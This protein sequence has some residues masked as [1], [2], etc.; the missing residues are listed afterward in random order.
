MFWMGCRVRVCMCCVHYISFWLGVWGIPW[1]MCPC[2]RMSL[3]KLHASIVLCVGCWF[4]R[5]L[6]W[7]VICGMRCMLS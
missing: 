2:R 5:V 7:F 3:L 4:V 1:L 6:I